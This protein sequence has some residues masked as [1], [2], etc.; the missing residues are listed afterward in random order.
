MDKLKITHC[1]CMVTF[2]HEKFIRQAFDSIFDNDILPDCVVLFD[3]CSSDKTWK[4]ILEYKEKYK[5]ILH[6]KRNKKNLG[7]FANIN[8]AWQ[9]GLDSGCDI[10]SWCSGDDFL[11]K[12]LF[13]EFNR[14]VQKENIDVKNEKFILVTDTEELYPNGKTKIYSN[15]KYRNYKD[16]L[17]LRLQGKLNYRDCGFSRKVANVPPFREDLGLHADLIHCIDLEQNCDKFYFSNFIGTVYRV[18]V[19]TVSKEKTERLYNSRI[20]VDEYIKKHYTLSRKSKKFLALDYWYH[21]TFLERKL[22]NYLRL[23]FF[24]CLNFDK[25]EYKY[26]SLYIPKFVKSIGKR[27][28]KNK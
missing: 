15:F 24:I 2:N 21:K 10:L 8:Q 7:I 25:L 18:G 22:E 5:D 19:G 20:I 26:I 13:A 11:K 6:C 28:L 9:A 1:V 16:T 4:I 27:I 23:T 12:N 17:Y 3:D 14:M